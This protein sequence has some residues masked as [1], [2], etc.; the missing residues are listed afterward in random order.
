MVTVMMM[1]VV[2]MAMVTFHLK[3]RERHK[4]GD[5]WWCT[6]TTFMSRLVR[7]AVSLV[8]VCV[9]VCA[10]ACACVFANAYMQRIART[11]KAQRTHTPS[12]LFAFRGNRRPHDLPATSLAVMRALCQAAT[13]Q[14]LQ[15]W[16]SCKHESVSA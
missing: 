3:D 16:V 4:K 12:P 5:M 1:V 9:C 7:S 2:V 15:R 11:P 10:C 6:S 8:C 14:S 13:Q